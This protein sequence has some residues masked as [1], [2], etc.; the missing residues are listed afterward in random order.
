MLSAFHRISEISLSGSFFK[1]MLKWLFVL[2]GLQFFN[3]KCFVGDEL[4]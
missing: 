4:K 2:V 1:F 3:E